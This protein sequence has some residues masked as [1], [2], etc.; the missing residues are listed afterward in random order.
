MAVISIMLAVISH[1]QEVLKIDC[2]EWWIY[3]LTFSCCAG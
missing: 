1:Q 3:N 2:V